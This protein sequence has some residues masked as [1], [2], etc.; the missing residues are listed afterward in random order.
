[1]AKT[2]TQLSEE[3]KTLKAEKQALELEIEVY[4]E[5]QE[6]VADL[7]GFNDDED[8]EDEEDEE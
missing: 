2:W 1:M 5:I 3:V 6:K 4:Q 7:F 8:N